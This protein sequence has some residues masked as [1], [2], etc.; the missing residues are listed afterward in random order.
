MNSYFARLPNWDDTTPTWVLGQRAIITVLSRLAKLRAQNYGFV[1][2]TNHL[3]RH[4][5]STLGNVAIRY[6][7]SL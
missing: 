6:N 7:S 1:L 5:S 4:L 2:R 3:V